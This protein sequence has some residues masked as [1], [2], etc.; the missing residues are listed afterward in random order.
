MV[1]ERRPGWWYPYIFVAGFM[2]V[3]LVNVTM[4]YFATSTF[5]GLST[6]HAYEKGLA[7]NQVLEAARKQEEMGWTVDTNVEPEANHG[8]HVTVSYRD[9]DGKPLDGLTVRASLVR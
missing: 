9:R 8:A 6:E 3:L 4:A 1:A 7:H 2:V 5:S